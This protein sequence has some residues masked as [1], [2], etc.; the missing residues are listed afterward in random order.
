MALFLTILNTLVDV[1]PRIG[2][3]C[4]RVRPT[5][6]PAEDYDFVV[7]GVKYN[8]IEEYDIVIIEL[9]K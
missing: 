7:I 1:N 8:D 4:G 6:D 5:E 9:R 3:P 2:D